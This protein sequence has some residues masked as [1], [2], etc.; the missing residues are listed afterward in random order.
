MVSLSSAIVG[1]WP[2]STWPKGTF[3][4]PST[5]SIGCPESSDFSFEVGTR[6][7]D[8]EDDNPVSSTSIGIHLE[9][10]VDSEKDVHMSFCSK[11]VKISDDTKTGGDWPSGKYCFFK[12]GEHCP[13]G[14]ED[15]W[16]LWKDEVTRNRN[17][18]KGLLPAGEYDIPNQTKILFCCRV[19]G[20]PD[21]MIELPRARSF[22]LLKYGDKC[23]QVEGTR[24]FEEFVVW[25][26]ENSGTG[27]ESGGVVPETGVTMHGDVRL[28]FCYYSKIQYCGDPGVPENGTVDNDKY[29]AGATLRFS[30]DEGY[31]LS[32]FDEITCLS[33][34]LWNA[35]VPAC[36]V[37]RPC[38]ED[39]GGCEQVCVDLGLGHH[40]CECNDGYLLSE[41]QKKCHDIDECAVEEISGQCEHQCV[42]ENGGYRCSCNNGYEL[43][44]DERTCR[45]LDECLNNPCDHKCQN[46]EGGYTCSCYPGYQIGSPPTKCD[47]VDE[48]LHQVCEQVCYN[49][50]GSY[51]CSCI[52]GFG[53][54]H[55]NK[56]C[57]NINPCADSFNQCEEKDSCRVLEIDDRKIAECSCSQGFRLN[58]DGRQ[59]DDINECTEGMHYCSQICDNTEG[60]YTCRCKAGYVLASDGYT[61]NDIDE[62]S[63][64]A[65]EGCGGCQH[66]CVNTVGSYHC[67][68]REQ[69]LPLTPDSTKCV[70]PYSPEDP[71]LQ[72]NC[73]EMKYAECQRNGDHTACVCKEGYFMNY[74]GTTCFEDHCATNPCPD[75]EK[76]QE[77]GEGR[78]CIPSD[79]VADK[80]VGGEMSWLNDNIMAVLITAGVVVAWFV[81]MLTVIM[82]IKRRRARKMKRN[83][84]YNNLTG[85]PDIT[86]A[87]LPSLPR[88]AM[89]DNP[90]YH[91]STTMQRE[92]EHEYEELDKLGHRHRKFEAANSYDQGLENVN[93][94]E[95][96]SYAVT[97]GP[98]P[99]S[100]V[101]PPPIPHIMPEYV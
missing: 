66:N 41:D 42:N 50:K 64:G 68:C 83:Y 27:A 31:K 5:K 56:S 49:I 61:C 36:K 82:I 99:P 75:N 15:G 22:A 37:I 54:D 52:E 23:Q 79:G 97:P 39:N 4:I 88:P 90:I 12:F 40:T 86:P 101:V 62:C 20:D 85:Y 77:Q 89:L 78:I 58:R 30:C 92:E 96:Y 24:I 8:C 16:I 93:E 3:S 87:P 71:C 21:K 14:F 70:I 94:G 46:T 65:R 26:N 45:D 32:G 76:C 59:C 57:I 17:D 19:D 100:H 6:I 34:E 35:D 44:P 51:K 72:R 55:D 67:S 80:N 1:Y 74:N 13:A 95:A 63:C 69:Y 43:S 53:L 98:P 29:T 18:K 9:L 48:C 73:L 33:T 84:G 81:I 91:S 11:T 28:N 2:H 38:K 10:I 60:D 47:D 25:D 7:F